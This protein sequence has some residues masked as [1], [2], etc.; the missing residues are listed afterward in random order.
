VVVP[1][2]AAPRPKADRRFCV[3]LGRPVISNDH[4]PD[5]LMR[6]ARPAFSAIVLTLVSLAGVEAQ[7]IPSDIPPVVVRRISQAIW[8]DQLFD[9]AG[10]PEPGF[11]VGGFRPSFSDLVI[12]GRAVEVS[13]LPGVRFYYGHAY[14][15]QCSHCQTYIAAV[16][17][18]GDSSLTLMG[19]NEVN[20]LTSWRSIP[21]G[22]ADSGEARRFV[23]ET[24]R[25][26]CLVGCQVRWLPPTTPL[27]G[28]DSSYVRHVD[29]SFAHWSRPRTY[30][31]VSPGQMTMEFLL[32]DPGQ[33]IYQIR[34][35]QQRDGRSLLYSIEPSAW[36]GL[37]P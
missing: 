10:R 14:P 6:L 16:A 7:S 2:R 37:S 27:S 15:S 34:V 29:G 3:H 21:I 9:S 4:P 32:I 25:A 23:V 17:V 36:F 18:L 19:P 20:K 28:N 26:T 11:N 35:Q 12:E 33:A 22:L 24:L 1:D 8:P 5:H 30:S 31:H 13:G